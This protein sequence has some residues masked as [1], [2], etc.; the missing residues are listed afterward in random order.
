[1][2]TVPLSDRYVKKGLNDAH[3]SERVG[4]PRVRRPRV[5]QVRRSELPHPP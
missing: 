3:R 2:G 4:E 5:D 1:V